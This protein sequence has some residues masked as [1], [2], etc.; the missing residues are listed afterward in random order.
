MPR[1]TSRRK[2]YK[3][4]DLGAWIKGKMRQKGM[5][6]EQMADALGI[7]QPAFSY[8]LK[9]GQITYADLLTILQRLETTDEEIV[10]LMKI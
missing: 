6:Q 7:T 4:D 9:S 8:K 2:F 10:H 5:T 1:I 3:V